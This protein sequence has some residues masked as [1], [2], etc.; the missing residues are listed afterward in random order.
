MQQDRWPKYSPDIAV[1]F[2]KTL[3]STVLHHFAHQSG[4]GEASTGE[5][6]GST[7]QDIDNA[8]Y[9]DNPGDYY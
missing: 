9:N 5:E 3:E 7:S 4:A 6:N 2:V 8:Q 1:V